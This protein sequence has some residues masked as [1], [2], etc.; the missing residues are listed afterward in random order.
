MQKP[1]FLSVGGHL[2]TVF[3]KEVHQLLG[4]SLS[5][6][7]QVSGEEGV[8]LWNEIENAL[9]G[10][11]L[12][13]VFWSHDYLK[14]DATKHELAFFRR[15]AESGTGREK[16]LLIVPIGTDI[17]NF[18]SR[19]TNP[20]T[21]VKDEFVLGEWRNVRSID[22][23]SDVKR[24]STVIRTKLESKRIIQDVLIPRGW[25]V[26][27][28]THAI[29]LPDYKMREL[30]F[31]SGLEGYGRRTVVRQYMRQA[32]P[33]RLERPVVLDSVD[34]PQ[35]FLIPL[36][37]AASMPATLRQEVLNNINNE[38]TTPIK[39]IRKILHQARDNRSY[40]IFSIE[41][42][43]GA[44]IAT[45]PFWMSEL[46]SVFKTG[47]NPLIFIITSGPISDALLSHFPD[48]ARIQVP[49]LEDLEMD[50]LV[51]RLSLEEK[52]P[53][54]W[55][56]AHKFTV[57]RACGNSP[58]LCKSVMNTISYEPNLDFVQQ[59]AKR[60][61]EN[62][63][64]ALAS[65]LAHW[66]KQYRD[67]RSDL[68]ALRI[69]EKLGVASGE[70]LDEII[71]PFVVQYGP[72][73][74]YGLR[75]QGLVEQLADGL[76]RIPKL[77]QRRLGSV[78][79][80]EIDTKEIDKLFNVFSQRVLVAKTEYGAMYAKN[81]ITASLRVGKQ[82]ATEYE[83]YLTTAMLFKSGR[84]RYIN[85]EYQVAF[86][87]FDRAMK[88]IAINNQYL[89]VVTIIEIV[90]FY[91]LSSVRTKNRGALRN[92]C[93]YLEESFNQGKRKSSALAMSLFLKGF[94]AR[95]NLMQFD[96]AVEFYEK[97]L[98]Q[99]QNEHFA[100]RQRGAIYTELSAS[101][102]RTSPPDYSKALDFA[103]EAFKQNDVIHTL[104][105]YI[106][107]LN[108][109][110]FESGRQTTVKLLQPYLNEIKSLLEKLKVRC[111]E[112]NLDFDIDRQREFDN[113]LTRWEAQYGSLPQSNSLHGAAIYLN[114]R[115]T[116]DDL[117]FE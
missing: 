77:I 105:V 111:E 50:E 79:W 2:D 86:S 81:A 74:L 95:Y 61:E 90:R 54:R 46:L 99:L 57:A 108:A 76:Y 59:I 69:I 28:M 42:F 114:N 63:G 82:I 37:D 66:T 22:V 117:S 53:G 26:D 109:Y 17:P 100:G 25:L 38:T 88:K 9:Q 98:H 103:K 102:L 21:G 19:W 58:S 47:S 5:Y 85:K 44:D 96:K 7:Y 116:P 112:L 32:A 101:Y 84:D 33:A 11:L 73:D 107:A 92:A 70:A 48:A 87:I 35:D 49:G 115:F 80:S 18:Q 20:I 31:I 16:E 97:A 52:V 12:F 91:G 1:V 40:Y 4:D 106:H 71:Q 14:S 23:N 45:I 43:I 24:I 104:N 55:T 51:H 34:G 113:G 67:K 39:E 3:A 30:V 13:V 29:R 78:L 62:F 75:N 6:H 8:N 94:E 65:L 60:A 93:Q 10:A 89:D 27:R 36:M 41:R 72:H 15:L 56:S 64:Q 110:T 83:A 68:V